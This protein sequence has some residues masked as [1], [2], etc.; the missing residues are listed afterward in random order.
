MTLTQEQ[1]SHKAEYAVLAENLPTEELVKQIRAVRRDGFLDR[2]SRVDDA[3]DLVGHAYAEKILEEA[4]VRLSKINALVKSIDLT[5]CAPLPWK[6]KLSLYPIA[7][8]GDYDSSCDAMDVTGQAVVVKMDG[9]GY[10]EVE[11]DDGDHDADILAICDSVNAVSEIKK[12]ITP[13]QRG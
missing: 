4:L 3:I 7:D 5:Q 12:I 6:S 10:R 11:K 2:H 1:S 9:P 13:N 8:T